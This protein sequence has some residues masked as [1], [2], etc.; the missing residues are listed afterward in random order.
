MLPK[1][2]VLQCSCDKQLTIASAR[3][4]ATIKF[5]Q[6]K[7]IPVPQRTSI[8]GM[9]VGMTSLGMNALS[10]GGVRL[11]PDCLTPLQMAR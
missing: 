2:I 10:T 9:H 7:L 4:D 3:R 1:Y 6:M 5:M 11:Y 8:K